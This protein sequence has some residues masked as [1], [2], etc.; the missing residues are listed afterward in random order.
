MFRNG[1]PRRFLYA[2]CDQIRVLRDSGVIS[3]IIWRESPGLAT[4]LF[5]EGEGWRYDINAD[6]DSDSFGRYP[7][8]VER[9]FHNLAQALEK[10][11]GQVDNEYDRAFETVVVEVFAILQGDRTG[12]KEGSIDYRTK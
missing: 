4:T 3:R 12:F 9:I 1:L 10:K 11:I 2:A 8:E 5:F 7:P 6:V